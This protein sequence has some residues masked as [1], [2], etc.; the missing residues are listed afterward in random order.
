MTISLSY[1]SWLEDGMKLTLKPL[2]ESGAAVFPGLTDE[3]KDYIIVILVHIRCVFSM[4]Y[5]HFTVRE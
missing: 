5:L 1:I 4:K 2:V 3:S